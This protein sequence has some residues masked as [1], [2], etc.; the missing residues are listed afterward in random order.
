MLTSRQQLLHEDYRINIDLAKSC[1]ADI[2]VHNCV[3]ELENVA[4]FSN[5][6]LST[7]LLCLEGAIKDG[8]IVKPECIA[9][10]KEVRQNLLSD[11]LS[12]PELVRD[13]SHEIAVSCQDLAGKTIHC[14][15]DLA[16]SSRGE[17]T[18]RERISDQCARTLEDLL[19]EADIGE[20]YEIDPLLHEACQPV[21][22][23][24]CRGIKPGEGRII[25][26]LM[27]SLHK[28]VM[29]EMCRESLMEVYYFVTRDFRLD[30]Q[31]YKQCHEDARSLCGA[32]DHWYQPAFG[33]RATSPGMGHIVFACL[34]RNALAVVDDNALAVVDDKKQINE[35]CVTEI[36]RVMRERSLSVDLDPEVETECMTDL[37][38]FCSHKTDKNE[39][40]EC[41]EE[42]LEHLEVKCKDV[43]KDILKA[44]G[45]D[46]TINSVFVEACSPFWDKYC[47]HALLAHK[48]EGTDDD[49]GDDGDERLVIGDDGLTS[50]LMTCL[51]QYKHHPMMN[52]KCLAGIEHH[53]FMSLKDYRFSHLFKESCQKDVLK[54]CPEALQKAKVVLCLS[55]A[56]RDDTMLQKTARISKPCRKQLKFELLQRS[57]NMKF[58]PD[59]EAV[60]SADAKKIV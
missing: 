13:C 54:H 29:T 49:E 57:E 15:M 47:Q 22:E 53:Q 17:H 19:T 3:K 10:M 24:V 11:Y 50:D 38:K 52:A 41:L 35:S 32:P 39:E 4:M 31:L 59:I 58:D 14:L 8:G 45:E 42:N 46:P 23:T 28:R 26:C 34:Y 55:E 36:K 7:V 18:G 51:I 9:E 33:P 56:V 16:R 6:L 20:S 21:V 25:A 48:K 44:E 2:I 60:C 12:S 40:M 27:S 1:Q 30:R 43:I 37:G 5:A